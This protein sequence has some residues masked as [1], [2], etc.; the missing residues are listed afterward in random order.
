MADVDWSGCM[1]TM[2]VQL[3]ASVGGGVPTL[4]LHLQPAVANLHKDPYCVPQEA[5]KE[6][7]EE[8]LKEVQAICSPSMPRWHCVLCM[9][10]RHSALSL[11]C[12]IGRAVL[13]HRL[14]CTLSRRLLSACAEA[15]A[16]SGGADGT[17]RCA[18]LN[19]LVH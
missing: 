18:T 13:T 7:Y 5:E 12:C 6:G 14:T 19:P 10:L 15:N 1:R 4:M 11:I 2:C 16:A 8:K 3:T 17:A 9:L